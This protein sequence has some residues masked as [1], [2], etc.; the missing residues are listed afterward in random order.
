VPLNDPADELFLKFAD[1]LRELE[2][3]IGERARPAVAE[4]R[5]QIS[6]AVAR[7]QAGDAPGA[8]NLIR[9]AMERLASL[10][11]ELD[12]DEGAM[13]RAIAHQF[14]RAIST[15]DTGSAKS[16]VDLMRRKAGDTSDKDPSD[17]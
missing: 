9:N 15:G 8:L 14:S 13:M 11:S 12:A 17:W 1:N 7:R 10:A 6:Q 3:I 4:V 5:A 2:V 16:A